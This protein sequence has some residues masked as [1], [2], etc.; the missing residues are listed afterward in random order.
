VENIE[1]IVLR[2]AAE[3]MREDLQDDGENYSIIMRF[4]IWRNVS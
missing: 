2:R 1:K 4:M 3:S